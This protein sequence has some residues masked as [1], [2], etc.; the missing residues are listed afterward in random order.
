MWSRH[1]GWLADLPSQPSSALR[2]PTYLPSPQV[3]TSP[4]RNAAAVD[5][6]ESSGGVVADTG[7]GY[8]G[9]SDAGD[10]CR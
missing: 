9:K 7:E 6:M 8:S 4:R 10:P 3:G 5:V 1:A 2:C